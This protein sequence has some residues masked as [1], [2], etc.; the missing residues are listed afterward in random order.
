MPCQPE[1]WPQPDRLDVVDIRCR[2]V[3]A[4]R[5]TNGECLQIL[6]AKRAPVIIVAALVRCRPTRVLLGLSSRFT[7]LGRFLAAGA[8]LVGSCRH[9]APTK[10][11]GRWEAPG[12]GIH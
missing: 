11:P 2:S 12:A 6:A 10:K 8:M 1:V 4:D 9:G 3:A 5:L 7:L